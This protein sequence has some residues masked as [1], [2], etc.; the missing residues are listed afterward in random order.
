MNLSF[1]I[2]NRL[3]LW[4]IGGV[5]L[6]FST[7]KSLANEEIGPLIAHASGVERVALVLGG[8]GARGAAHI[9]V[10]EVLER[11]RI[12]VSCVVGTSM[13]GLVAGAYVAG[14]SPKLMR[15][16]LKNADWAD[17]FTDKAD[18]SQL[19]YRTKKINKDL[20]AGTEIG[21]SKKG[22]VQYQS[23][24]IAGE[25][26]KLFFNYLVGDYQGQ[27]QIEDSRLPL[28]IVATDIGTGERVVLQEGSLSRAMRA[29]M[30][31]PGLM[32]PV[33]ID[34]HKL[35]DGGLVD[36]LP[37][38][39]ARELCQATRVIAVNVGTK[40]RAAEEVNSLVSVTAQMIGILTDQN[41]HRSRAA[42]NEKDIYIEP[43]LGDITATDFPRYA[44]AADIGKAAAEAQ[45]EKLRQLSVSE[46]AYA[47]WENTYQDT[48]EVI[49]TIDEIKIAG[50]DLVPEV[51][52]KQ[53]IRQPLNQP[54]DRT[55]LDQDLIRLYGTGNFTVVDYNIYREGE[56]SILEVLPSERSWTG[57]SVLFGFSIADEYRDGAQINLRGA[58]RKK[59][60]NTRGGEFF[61]LFDIGTEPYLEMEFYQ[62]LDFR[63]TYFIEPRFVLNRDDIN[64]FEGNNKVAEY[65]LSTNQTDLSLGRNIGLW[66][67]AR[68]GWRY[69]EVNGR[70]DYNP[71][72]LPNIE[73][74]YSGVVGRVVFDSRNRLYFPSQGW[75]GDLTYFRE[76]NGHY[77]KV[78]ADL[79]V[80]YPLRD[81]VVGLYGNY[82][83]SVA[84]VLPIY[85]AASL[86]GFLNLSGYA[87]NQILAD[88]TIYGHVR[89]EKIIGR[90]PLGFN[91]DMRMGLTLETARV[92]DA[93]TLSKPDDTLSSVGLFFGGETP[94]GPAYVGYGH[95]LEGAH[96]I[97]FQIGLY[98]RFK[99]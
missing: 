83:A 47:E 64:L 46:E 97:Y 88:E 84:G 81:F 54:I 66:G 38:E 31:V 24:M 11:E 14:V 42:L 5:L 77:E 23:G 60:I 21:L 57:D 82:T 53:F 98:D 22:G 43:A 12:P 18:Y 26:I 56:K 59:W 40:L 52:I 7:V 65:R 50:G 73:A 8:G 48:R 93:Y 44:Q 95:S 41:V 55:I 20:I 86:G 85:D 63:Q 96:N 72:N 90:M 67:Q 35:V 15:E 49:E 30:S 17:M 87:H 25:K 27:R 32:A 9:G 4:V 62:P 74:D 51:Y 29:S 78:S 76:E 94:F 16:K 37:V 58:Y 2:N 1:R 79:G 13:G 33:E 3:L 34:G 6:P 28:A 39:L 69:F 36:N 10:V 71:F 91:G 45:L 68:L 75:R 19:S 99:F 61:A 70:S 80:A 89:L 92:R